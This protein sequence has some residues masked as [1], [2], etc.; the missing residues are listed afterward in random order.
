MIRARLA[1]PAECAP[2]TKAG[3]ETS[4]AILEDDGYRIGCVWFSTARDHVLVH[5]LQV[6]CWDA[7]ACAV[8]LHFA[9][10]HLKENRQSEIHIYETEESDPK[11]MEFWKRLGAKKLL[12]MYTLRL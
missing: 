7:S 4:G 8:L 5:G 11:V 9:R 10:R 2:F 3:Y 12:T 1:T 6:A